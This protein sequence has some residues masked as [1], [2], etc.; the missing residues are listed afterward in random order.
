MGR[1]RESVVEVAVAAPRVTIVSLNVTEAMIATVIVNV[2]SM[3]AIG[4]TETGKRN[5]NG[6]GKGKGQE[7]RRNS[8]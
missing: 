4:N 8:G 1:R 5:E 3:N 7:T 2:P 6:K